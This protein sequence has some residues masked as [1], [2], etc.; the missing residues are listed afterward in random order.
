VEG[1]TSIFGEDEVPL[2]SVQKLLLARPVGL[3]KL[4]LFRGT[5]VCSRQAPISQPTAI[6]FRQSYGWSQPY[7]NRSE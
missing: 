1:G 2:K 7:C 6:G 5:P 4:R 3:E